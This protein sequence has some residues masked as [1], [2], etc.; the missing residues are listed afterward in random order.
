[1][2]SAII[3]PLNITNAGAVP[4]PPD[5]LNQILIQ[6]VAALVPD[7]TANLPG[8]L[9]EDLTSTG[10]GLLVLIDQAR[11]D[12]IN[13]LT[14]TAINPATLQQ[15]G[16]AQ[17]IPQG[18]G[19]NVS[20]YVVFSGPSGYLISPGWTVSDGTNQYIVQDGGT[21]G[22]S[23]STAPLYCVSTNAS[24]TL[25]PLP[26]TVTTIVTSV[27]SGYT[28]TCTNPNSGTPAST[29][30]TVQEYR[31]QILA[32][33]SIT[34][35]GTADYIKT[36]VGNVPGVNPRLVGVLQAAGGWEVLV[37]GGDPYQVAGAIYQAVLD[38]G[39]I[40]GSSIS[41]SRDVTVTITSPPNTYNV[42]FV[43]PPDQTVTMNVVWNTNL[44]NFTSGPEVNQLAQPALTSYIN[45][46][47]V[48]Q[49]INLL[50]MTAV[51]QNAVASVLPSGNLT[52]L[53]FTVYINGTETAPDA[54]TSIIPGDPESYFS[55]TATAVTV[56]QG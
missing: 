34:V 38:L 55:A 46:I 6:N 37:G 7:Y 53:D 1:M 22:T 41:S 13:S 54:G 43:S 15:L 4:N 56:V 11:V 36:L 2:S 31:A 42:T 51:F 32:A 29:P 5:T 27:P 48:G 47:V 30:Q 10:T 8:S 17:G 9:I 19:A 44:P 18:I 52:V 25:A 39:T 23:G 12:A 20:V 24:Q 45:S 40:V 35:Q 26:N 14:P 49:P 16:Q 50:E 28:I 21:I 33:Q 3:V